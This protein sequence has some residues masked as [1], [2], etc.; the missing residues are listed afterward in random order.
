MAHA[1]EDILTHT[2]VQRGTGRLLGS[3][4]GYGTRGQYNWLRDHLLYPIHHAGEERW[5]FVTDLF[6]RLTPAVVRHKCSVLT[7]ETALSHFRPLNPRRRTASLPR[8][9]AAGDH[10][11]EG[12]RGGY[13]A[14]TYCAHIN[15]IAEELISIDNQ[16]NLRK[17]P[18]NPEVSNP[19]TANWATFWRKQNFLFCIAK[20]HNFVER[21]TRL[22]F[23]ICG[24]CT[25]A[26]LSCT[27]PV[28][29][30]WR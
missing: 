4:N 1:D 15:I 21:D 23:S 14:A 2:F 22:Y 13:A 20:L 18:K 28:I 11:L 6:T 24:N 27:K 16:Q 10:N 7:S 29:A 17:I 19:A 8:G 30:T 25:K 26:E 9:C 12:K 3:F 5:E